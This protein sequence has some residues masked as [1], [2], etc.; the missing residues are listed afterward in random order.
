MHYEWTV[1]AL[2]A[3]KHV[4]CEK[5]FMANAREARKVMGLAKERGLVLEEAVCCFSCPTLY[6]YGWVML[7]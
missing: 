6:G 3:G 4:L 7:T 5:P 1:K 2:K